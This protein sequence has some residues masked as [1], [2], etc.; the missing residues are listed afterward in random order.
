[1]EN[2]RRKF[3]KQAA[4]GVTGCGVGLPVLSD[5][6]SIVV[7]KSASVGFSSFI[8]EPITSA[9]EARIIREFTKSFMKGMSATTKSSLRLLMHDYGEYLSGDLKTPEK[10]EFIK[11]LERLD[12]AAKN[13]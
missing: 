8:P 5:L 2:S 13:S 10:L 4:I 12:H 7:H 6:D 9:D 1:M 11:C 3:I